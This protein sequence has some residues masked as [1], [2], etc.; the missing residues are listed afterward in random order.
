[1][2]LDLPIIMLAAAETIVWAGLYYI[3]PALLVHWEAELGWSKAELTGAFTASIA[4]MALCSPYVGRL[5]D[6]GHG[7]VLLSGGAAIGGILIW[8]LSYVSSLPA[9][10]AVWCALGVTM[11]TCLYE[12]CFALVTRTRG[13][14]A[15]RAITLITLAAGFAGTLAFPTAHEIAETADWRLAAKVAGVAVLVLAVPLMILGTRAL[16]RA[17]GDFVKAPQEKAKPAGDSSKNASYLANPCFWLLAVSFALMA[18]SHGVVINHLLPLLKERGVED[19]LAVAAASMIGPMQV[20]GRVVMMSVERYISNFIAMCYCYIA[21]C[22]ACALLV[23]A[24]AVP[25]LLIGFVFL[26]GSGYGLTSIMKPV[27]VRD[28]LGDAN[29]GAIS[30]AIA[31]PYL[32][33]FAGAPFLGSLLWEIGG[34]GFA[35]ETVI[36]TTILG[37]IC[38]VRA[39]SLAGKTA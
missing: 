10:Y 2:R 8:C 31:L 32:A 5:I 4:T 34:Y 3:F 39:A 22:I 35:L 37:L 11:A 27:V 18:L 16:E 13:V 21:V 9:F 25:M 23:G 29:F 20:L 33:S 38:Y 24:G 15:K 30:G 17:R 12:P 28:I 6:R 1:M 7:P 36:V 26:Q 14:A 19:G